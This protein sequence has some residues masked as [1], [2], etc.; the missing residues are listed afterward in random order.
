MMV[1]SDERRSL[2]REEEGYEGRDSVVEIADPDESK[3]RIRTK[4][5]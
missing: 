3:E 1:S 5:E 2:E 4:K